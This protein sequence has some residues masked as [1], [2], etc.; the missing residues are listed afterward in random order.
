[1]GDF[2]SSRT[3]SKIDRLELS[4]SLRN[5]AQILPKY[6][7]P[8][9]ISIVSLMQLMD[10]AQGSPRTIRKRGRAD[11][12][13]R[14]RLGLGRYSARQDKGGGN[15]RDSGENRVL[16][17]E[18]IDAHVVREMGR[19][20]DVADLEEEEEEEEQEEQEQEEQE[21]QDQDQEEREE[22]E[23]E[24]EQELGQEGKVEGKTAA[25]RKRRRGRKA[26]GVNRADKEEKRLKD[27]KGAN[28]DDKKGRSGQGAT[29]GD[30]CDDSELDVPLSMSKA[31][32]EVISLGGM[33][34]RREGGRKRPRVQSEMED[35]EDMRDQGHGKRLKS[36]KK[37]A[38]KRPGKTVEDAEEPVR[39]KRLISRH[40]SHIIGTGVLLNDSGLTKKSCKDA[41]AAVFG[42]EAVKKK[43]RAYISEEIARITHIVLGCR[44][45]TSDGQ[46]NHEK[47][48]SF[49][50]S[51]SSVTAQEARG[52][53]VLD[54]AVNMTLARCVDNGD[55][56][57]CEVEEEDEEEA[58]IKIEE[59]RIAQERRQRRDA[60]AAERR[61]Q[62]ALRGM[63]SVVTWLDR[64]NVVDEEEEEEE[65]EFKGK[66]TANEHS[67]ASASASPSERRRKRVAFCGL[68][69]VVTWLHIP[70]AASK[71][72]RRRMH[73][74]FRGMPTVVTWLG[75]RRCHDG[76]DDDQDEEDG[77]DSEEGDTGHGEVLV[78]EEEEVEEEEMQENDAEDGEE[79][80]EKFEIEYILKSRYC[81]IPEDRYVPAEGRGGGFEKKRWFFI[82]W[83]G[84]DDSYNEWSYHLDQETIDDYD[85]NGQYRR[86]RR[87]KMGL[88]AAERYAV[89]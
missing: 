7:I 86:P 3:V 28:D 73:V 65:E 12:D 43:H 14:D 57:D 74:A 50:A 26:D 52:E 77:Y 10:N 75:E 70:A 18:E 24:E 21:E 16:F 79:K 2:P 36:S 80:E 5:L 20:N 31:A 51:N 13:G 56:G 62:I 37:K 42:D 32:T 58:R 19:G 84:Y 81:V 60:A 85:R 45:L 67:S 69:S 49:L 11:E 33:E 68:P 72:R 46:V 55:D 47:L 83:A 82:K 63:P 44:M 4:N 40:I 9:S 59:Q 61:R 22:E 88:L 64:R 6:D 41:L 71:R 87:R 48:T 54:N 66:G 30:A 78:E 38:S 89:K 8:L 34:G 76:Q 53:S 29:N 35:A 17:T 25:G 23:E 15:G 27:K 39:I 1:M